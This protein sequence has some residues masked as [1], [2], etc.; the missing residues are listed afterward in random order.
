MK[1]KKLI[2]CTLLSLTVIG[3]YSCKKDSTNSSGDEVATTLELSG[4]DAIAES[5]VEDANDI[6]METG[7]N[8]N[9]A[10]RNYGTAD[11][12][13]T[14]NIL[15][16][17]DVTVTPIEGFPKTVVIDFGTGCTSQL[18]GVTRKGKITV[19]VS[20]SLRKSG[21]VA[22]MNFENYYVDGYK[23]EGAIT[24]TNT[25]QPGT[26]SWER[27]CAEGKITAPDGRYWMHSGTKVLVQTEGVSTP[28]NLVDDVYSITGTHTITNA[29]GKSSTSTILEALEKKT[30]CANVDKGKV[31][32]EG[33]KHYA[34]IDF[35]DGT[36][37]KVAT[38]S[39]DGSNPQS[40]LLR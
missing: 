37:D 7:V 14:M 40:F 6:L 32:I 18:T 28:Y 26:R 33:P 9:F 2:L 4:N 36:C 19:T 30:T 34:I 31:K 8:K 10:G 20:D 16:C 1:I 11:A 21:S 15:G 38:I 35:G 5:I 13:Q 27:K 17:G 39:I 3:F 25:S 12:T 23:K 29:A 22:V 24:W